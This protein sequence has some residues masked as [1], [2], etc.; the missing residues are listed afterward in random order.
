VLSFIVTEHDIYH[1][2]DT[3]FRSVIKDMYMIHPIS[4]FRDKN[5]NNME[6]YRF[7]LLTNNFPV[8][9][10]DTFIDMSSA[11]IIL[12]LKSERRIKH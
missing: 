9:I 6:Y 7:L 1:I 10:A 2:R 12:V 3:H 4:I 8:C 11:V 5:G